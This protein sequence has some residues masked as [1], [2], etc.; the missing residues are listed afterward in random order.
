MRD[1]ETK[2]VLLKY[3]TDANRHMKT[4]IGVVC[5]LMHSALVAMGL[6]LS[7][8][9]RS[10]LHSTWDMLSCPGSSIERSARQ[11]QDRMRKDCSRIKATM[12]RGKREC[13]GLEHPPSRR[14]KTKCANLYPRV[15]LQYVGKRRI[16]KKH[17]TPLSSF[18][19]M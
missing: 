11:S 4:K 14:R 15:H 9:C 6:A 13:D 2:S 7:G 3:A 18:R 17:D 10:S 1:Y 16:W 19:I 5:P 8:P 12:K